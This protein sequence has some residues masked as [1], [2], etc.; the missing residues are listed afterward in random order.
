MDHVSNMSKVLSF[1]FA[2]TVTKMLKKLNERL[3]TVAFG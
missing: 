3:K 2:N 1:L